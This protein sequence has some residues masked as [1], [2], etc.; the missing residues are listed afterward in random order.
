MKT[1]SS[2]ECFLILF[3]ELKTLAERF[4]MTGVNENFAHFPDTK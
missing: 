2:V 3:L 1:T 4:K